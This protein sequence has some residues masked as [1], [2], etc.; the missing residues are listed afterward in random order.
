MSCTEPGGGKGAGP[1]APYGTTTLPAS[2]VSRFA[3]ALDG[4]RTA[5]AAGNIDGE[6][7]MLLEAALWEAARNHSIDVE[8]EAF[9]GDRRGV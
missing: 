8:L 6:S 7:V 1:I 4:L 2:A 5:H 9:L 3:T